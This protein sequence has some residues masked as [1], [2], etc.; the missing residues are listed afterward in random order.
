MVTLRA[1]HATRCA[2]ARRGLHGFG[3][4]MPAAVMEKRA[5]GARKTGGST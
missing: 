3:L 2:A 1:D 5:K 4:T